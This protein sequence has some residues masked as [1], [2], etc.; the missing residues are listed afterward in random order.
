MARSTFTIQYNCGFDQ[1]QQKV[2]SVLAA[3]RFAETTLKTGETV[4]KKGTGLLTAMQYVKV[5]YG[6]NTVILSA[7]VQAGIGSLAGDEMDLT[8]FV[9]AVPKGQL[10]KVIE[11]IKRQF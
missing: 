2:Q 10:L 3:K 6:E 4:W 11:E 5:E 1:A 8:G 7:W 9:A